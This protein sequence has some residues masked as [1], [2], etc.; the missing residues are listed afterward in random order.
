MIYIW[1]IYKKYIII[2]LSIL[3]VICGI[4]YKNT[5]YDAQVV[6]VEESKETQE[7]K[8]E[9]V[10]EETTAKL[11]TVYVCGSVKTAANV[12]LPEDSR[13]EDAVRLA[14]GVTEDADL[15]AINMAQKLSDS[16][17]VYVPKK[18]EV[19]QG[20]TSTKGKIAASSSVAPS[21]H[22]TAGIVGSQSGGKVNINNATAAEL[23]ALPGIGPSTADKIIN[24]RLSA[25][26]A[27][28]SL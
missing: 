5:V 2:A 17:M 8:E 9:P 18:G 27:L 1:R 4:V 7:K 12:T 10:K 21:T 23:D 14:G 16:D 13:I 24:Y 15:N 20:K 25:S 22:A 6:L 26:A 11:I 3:L 28:N 19:A